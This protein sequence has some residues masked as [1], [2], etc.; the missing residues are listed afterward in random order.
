[1]LNLILVEDNIDLAGGIVDYFSL[2]NMQCDHAN[3]GVSGLN[4][5]GKN[6][7]QVIILDLGLP[8]MDGLTL[9]QS[10]REQGIDTPIIMLTARDELDDKIKGFDAGA[11]DYLV[12][13]FEM[14]ELVVRVR[15]LSRRRS[16]QVKSLN[17]GGITFNLLAKKVYCGEQVLKLSP[18]ALKILEVLMRNSPS[19]VE[20]DLL[21]QRVWG[22][23]APDSNSLKVHIH[24]LRKQLELVGQGALLQTVK[25]H[26]FVFRVDEQ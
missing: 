10:I 21:L 9:C 7:Y 14:D 13:P 18:I 17:V 26:G 2:E 22:D 1:M 24:H 8:K 16:G 25:G 15:A 11:D 5:I 6:N 3:N 12:K 23:T 20:R 4:L 19:T